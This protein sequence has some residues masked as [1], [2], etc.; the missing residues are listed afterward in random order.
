[1]IL[2]RHRAHLFLK[3]GDV[4]FLRNM[5]WMMNTVGALVETKHYKP[6]RNMW[7]KVIRFYDTAVLIVFLERR[8]R[9]CTTLGLQSGMGWQ[10]LCTQVGDANG[11]RKAR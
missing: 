10:I 1:M 11:S 2:D 5:V 8:R 4:V 3:R 7:D 9:S 6:G